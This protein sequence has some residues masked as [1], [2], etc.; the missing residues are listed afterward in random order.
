MI[1]RASIKQKKDEDCVAAP[2]V[3]TASPCRILGCSNLG[4][5]IFDQV[6]TLFL[7]ASTAY[8]FL[9]V[10]S[11]TGF[12]RHRVKKGEMRFS[13]ACFREGGGCGLLLWVDRGHGDDDS[14]LCGLC[15]LCYHFHL[16]LCFWGV[17]GWTDWENK[18][19][20]HTCC[21]DAVRRARARQ[22]RS[23]GIDFVALAFDEKGKV[24]LSSSS[25]A[26]EGRRGQR[27]TNGEQR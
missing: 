16:V 9:P 20:E 18:A 4:R 17:R 8:T 25:R 14:E 5:G 26:A 22:N 2:V 13:H 24:F 23:C 21:S 1:I 19:E 3:G 15:G 12:A 6:S 7:N 27:G 10:R 11:T